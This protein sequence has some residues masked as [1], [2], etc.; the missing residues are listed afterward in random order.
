MNPFSCS[1]P[2]LICHLA[3]YLKLIGKSPSRGNLDTY[4]LLNPKSSYDQ[5]IDILNSGH[6]SLYCQTLGCTYL[7]TYK[8]KDLWTCW[9]FNKPV[10]FQSWRPT[11]QESETVQPVTCD[12]KTTRGVVLGFFFFFWALNTER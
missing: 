2:C 3:A 1:T 7:M 9:G 10:R 12:A 8:A 11:L 5:F 4:F 6:G